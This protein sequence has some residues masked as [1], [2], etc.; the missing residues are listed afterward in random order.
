MPLLRPSLPDGS[1]A[2]SSGSARRR[3]SRRTR[4]T[5]RRWTSVR[6]HVEAFARSGTKRAG[7]APEPEERLLHGVLGE[8]LVAEHAV[9]E[10][11]GGAAEA[12]VELGER[13][14]VGPRDECDER[15]V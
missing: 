14:L 12:V 6:I 15:F 11:V 1:G 7:A 9:G 13:G 3:C 10:P 5:A 8:R 2:P 4:S